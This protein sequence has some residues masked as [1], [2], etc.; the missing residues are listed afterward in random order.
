MGFMLR[1]LVVNRQLF[2]V[3]S[4]LQRED[5]VAHGDHLLEGDA[6][7][8]NVRAAVDTVH[9]GV[10]VVVAEVALEQVVFDHVLGEC[11][12]RKRGGEEDPEVVGRDLLE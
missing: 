6:L 7:E 2:L 11:L 4:A 9:G 8:R 12:P 10:V 5:L 1:N 3:G